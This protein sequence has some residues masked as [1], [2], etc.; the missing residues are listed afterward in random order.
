MIT[1]SEKLLRGIDVRYILPASC[2]AR[3]TTIEA[4]RRKQLLSRVYVQTLMRITNS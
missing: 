2:Y 4:A 3:A 1:S